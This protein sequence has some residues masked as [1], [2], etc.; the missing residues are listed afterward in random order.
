MNLHINPFDRTKAVDYSDDELFNNWVDFPERGFNNIIR[1]TLEMPMII[2]GSKGSG[3]TH[4]M[5]HFSFK[6]QKL[7]SDKDI[8]NT[9]IEEGYI[10]IYLRCSGLNGYR[11]SGRN[12]TQ[13]TWNSVF[14]YYLE[15]WLSQLYLDSIIEIVR[16]K[17][18]VD[19]CESTIV[20]EICSLFSIEQT[21]KIGDF[22]S[23]KN[24]INSQQ[25]NIDYAINNISL[26]LTS[27]KEQIN[28]LVNPG[29]LI[30]GI[31]KIIN[32]FLPGFSK[33]KS[34]FLLDEYENFSE[35]QQKYF[36]TLIRERKDPVCFKI[37]A[38]RYGL[39]TRMT[40]SGNEEI[41]AGSEYELFDLDDIFRRYTKSYKEFLKEIFL[42]RIENISPEIKLNLQTHFDYP[43]IEKDF[44]IISSKK[45][46]IIKFENKLKK[47]K[48][49]K[50]REIV[51]NITC[52]SN[53]L[54]ERL[55]IYLIYRGIKNNDDIFKLSKTLKKYT[56]QYLSEQYVEEYDK[57][58]DK[59]K[60]D[61]IDALYR[62][63]RLK[64][65]SYCG[66]DNL[67]RISNGIPRHFLMI[68]KHIYRWYDFYDESRNTISTEIQLLAIRD[69][70]Q[71]FLEDANTGNASLNFKYSIE[72][73]C[74]YLREIR[75]SDLPPEC[76]I[77][78]IE[79]DDFKYYPD[80]E[81]IF[82]F[83]EQYSYFI[84][85]DVGRRDKNSNQR[86]DTYQVNGLLACWWELSISRRGILKINEN[87][88]KSILAPQ[89]ESEY[90][91]IIRQELL[92]YNIPFTTTNALGENNDGIIE[93]LF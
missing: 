29:G 67:V 80:L 15:L 68:M 79:I 60:Q 7:R 49:L 4:I 31:P 47:I 81:E 46:H 48:A 65:D 8:Y 82:S 87:N 90:K 36:N 37:G 14:S 11:F 1:P 23:L 3:K 33:I 45:K 2:L 58:L 57:V 72:R 78:T 63:N 88:L 43:N 85:I 35:N 28:I 76:S 6:M 10:G 27:I 84:K 61:L 12:E 75:F 54:I 89:D 74:N 52:V 70:V 21:E 66:F 20:S 16:V 53:P 38:R 40:L 59:Y 41:K 92:K 55:N 56:L 93:S 86:K 18:E 51:S 64:L 44:K 69:T 26:S 42:K 62:E 25:K 71:W 39:K 91:K 24:F 30:F 77:S 5:K 34:V 73:L 50:I 22:D 13:D 32:K 17:T 19:S 9:I 83:L